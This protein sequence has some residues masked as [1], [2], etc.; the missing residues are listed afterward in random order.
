MYLGSKFTNFVNE[1]ISVRM[2]FYSGF[3]VQSVRLILS[4]LQGK[5]STPARARKKNP[6]NCISCC[7][8]GNITM[9]TPAALSRSV[10]LSLVW[11]L[12]LFVSFFLFCF[13]VAFYLRFLAHRDSQEFLQRNDILRYFV[14]IINY[15]FLPPLFFSSHIIQSFVYSAFC[16]DRI[17]FTYTNWLNE[18]INYF[19]ISYMIFS[20]AII[21]IV[22]ALYQSLV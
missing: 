17:S 1:N 7:Y 10:C 14:Y 2:Y 12:S 22:S 6:W 5:H 11:W 4:S 9:A 8:H 18:T 16:L 21:D 19:L 13:L 20:C 3:S 15:Y